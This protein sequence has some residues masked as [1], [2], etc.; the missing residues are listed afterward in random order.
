MVSIDTQRCSGCGICV[1]VCPHAVLR[2]N[3]SSARV[4]A[5][6]RCIEC[7][8]CMLNCKAQAVTVT[9][10]TGCLLVIIKEDILGIKDK[11]AA[12]CG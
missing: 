3:A 7:G 1:L 6:D 4:A 11:E 9:K 8:A 12:C 2:M 10:G 5:A